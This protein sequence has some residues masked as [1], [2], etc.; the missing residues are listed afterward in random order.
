MTNAAYLE[1]R[2]KFSRPQA[3]L[4]SNNPGSPVEVQDPSSD[5]PSKKITI[6]LPDNYEKKYNPAGVSDTTM[7]DDFLILSD[8]NREAI[9][10]SPERLES[11][12]RTINGRMRSYHVADKLKFDISWTNLPSRAFSENPK[13]NSL[14]KATAGTDYTVD[15]G[16]G[17]VDLLAWYEAHTG[18]FYMFLAYDKHELFSG[19]DS[20]YMRMK[21][22][23]QVVEVYITGFTYKINKRGNLMDL[24]DVSVNLEE[25]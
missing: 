13:F 6:Y 10:V 15:G 23:N 7:L 16:A 18:P 11:R 21:Y 24:W 4:W 2:K 5:D 22:Y 8:H 3:V 12:E 20:E 17:G 19:T 14:G 25:V 1:G 9:S